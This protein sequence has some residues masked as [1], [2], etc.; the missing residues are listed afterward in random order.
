VQ[1]A[2]RIVL[3]A[4]LIVGGCLALGLAAPAI[5]DRHP[6][7]RTPAPASATARVNETLAELGA[8]E[9]SLDVASSRASV[10]LRVARR[11]LTVARRNLARRL[12]TLY[13]TQQTEP[14]EVV[15]GATSVADALAGLDSIRRTADQDCAWVAEARALRRQAERLSRTLASQRLA[16]A[17]LRESAEAAAAALAALEVPRAPAPRRIAARSAPVVARTP[18]TAAPTPAPGRT[19]L[20]VVSAYALP[21][22]TATGTPVGYGIAA[23]DPA[24]IPLGTHLS[25]PG[26]GEAIAADTGSAI[27]GT[28]IDVWFPTVERARA[29][30]TRSVTVTI[31]RG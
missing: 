9:A 29:W 16:V 23:V 6:A 13:E 3:T 18:V 31:Q 24:V 21:G 30:G 19:A 26:Y 14:L 22:F 17:R 20:L 10:Q 1:E 27:R 8:R 15:L 28:R 5:G 12:R 25:I 2:P 4:A 11:L 7:P